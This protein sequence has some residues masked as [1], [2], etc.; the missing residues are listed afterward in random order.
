MRVTLL[1]LTLL[2]SQNLLAQRVCEEFITDEW[3]NIRYD[4][5][6]ASEVVLDKQTGLMWKRCSEGLS[7]E[8]CEAG[9]PAA[10]TW[11]SALATAANN[12]SAVFA[13]YSDWRLPNIKELRSIVASNCSNPAI[14]ET[15][16]PNTPT[17]TYWSSSPIKPSNSTAFSINFNFG[18]DVNSDVSAI[19]RLVRTEE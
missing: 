16:F 19:I 17:V 1:L 3:P 18:F 12:N 14:N 9:F 10:S 13:G 8:S 7:G 6:I 5:N 15:A 2:I 4:I 11:S